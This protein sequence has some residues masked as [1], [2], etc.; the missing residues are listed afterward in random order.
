LARILA[1]DWGE[2]RIGL[3][4]SDPTGTIASGLETLEVRSES[5]AV[6]RV[7]AVATRA[8]ATSILVGLP[9]LLSGERGSAAVAAEGFAARLRAEGKLPVDTFDERLTSAI[10][11]RRMQEVGDR[12]SRKKG[13]VDQGAAIAL[14]ETWL[15]RL[16]VRAREAAAAPP[17][18]DDS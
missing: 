14:L 5:D 13:R 17:A 3:A 18:K 4:I 10:S 12:A 15:Q 16:A 2:R 9:L 7:L 11:Q 1:V 8:E 6:A